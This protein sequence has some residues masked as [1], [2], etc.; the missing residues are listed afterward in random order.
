MV[1]LNAGGMRELPLAELERLFEEELLGPR[2]RI[3]YHMALEHQPESIDDLH[4]AL[5]HFVDSGPLFVEEGRYRA[6]WWLVP[7][8]VRVPRSVENRIRSWLERW[9]VL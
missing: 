3:L 2:P 9:G 5:D 8:F 7:R 4:A 6:V 1:G